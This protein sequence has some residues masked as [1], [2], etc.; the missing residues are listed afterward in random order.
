MMEWGAEGSTVLSQGLPLM[1][2]STSESDFF[3][4]SVAVERVGCAAAISRVE[5]EEEGS[6]G[7]AS[8]GGG[9]GGPSQGLAAF[10]AGGCCTC[11]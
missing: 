11:G 4:D 6:A 5:S 3:R 1:R 7:G 2:T 10:L 8:S 9:S